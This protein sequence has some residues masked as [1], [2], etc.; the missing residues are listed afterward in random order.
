[1]TNSNLGDGDLKLRS[2]PSPVVCIRTC[3]LTPKWAK[4]DKKDI[5]RM[6][7][8]DGMGR[9]RRDPRGF[10]SCL[11]PPCSKCSTRLA[12]IPLPPELQHQQIP[13]LVSTVGR[14]GIVRLQHLSDYARPEQAVPS[15]SLR[16][17]GGL[18]EVLEAADQPFVDRHDE[19]LLWPGQQLGRQQVPDRFLQDVL[20]A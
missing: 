3:C 10:N 19:S 1:M 8:C 7:R 17:Q 18:D 13:D 20:Y 2:F 11:P 12:D 6:P 5:S 14:A 9:A 4:S 15:Q 16:C